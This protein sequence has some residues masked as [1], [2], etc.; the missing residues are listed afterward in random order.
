VARF[1]DA[2]YFFN[3]DRQQPLEDYLPRLD[4][5]TFQEKL[6]SMLDKTNRVRDMVAPFAELLG[7]AEDVVPVAQ[8]AAALAKADLATQMVVE[9]TSLQGMMGRIYAELAGESPEVANA[10]F[11]HWLPRSA[12]DE[13]PTGAPGVM[14][15]LLDRLDSL[16]GLFAIDLAPTAS[17]DPFALRRAALGIIQI[18]QD[19]QLELDLRGA[20]KLVAGY[21]PVP[22]RAEDQAAVLDYIVGRLRVWLVEAGQPREVIEAVLAE[23]GHNPVRAITGVEELRRWTE[24]PEWPPIL[25]S[26]ARCARIVR[27]YSD[28]TLHPDRFSEKAEK[29]LFEA[30][31]TA[32]HRLHPIAHNVDRFLASFVT[33]VP[34][35]TRFFDDVLV[36]DED[37]AVR[38][39]RLALLQHIV[40]L[41]K[42]RADLS[43]LQGF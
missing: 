1:T 37:R 10:I 32:S 28:F 42:G 41:A 38:E 11:Q 12:D 18:L 23:Q 25:D 19:Q 21:Q 4:T 27:S 9:M 7:A 15:A 3:A 6:G 26:Y 39:N 29:A 34:A 20:I 36:M 14:L 35:I 24:Q 40:A 8:R 2:A 17:A 33:M 16:V 13:L 31:F 43:K 5:L 22:V 30:Y